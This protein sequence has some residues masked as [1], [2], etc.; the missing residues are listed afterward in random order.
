MACLRADVPRSC[1][2]HP[3]TSTYGYAN[4]AIIAPKMAS[5]VTPLL[6]LTPKGLNAAISNGVSLSWTGLVGAT[7]YNIQRATN[8]G[9]PYMWIG[10]TTATHF[11]DST[12]TNAI[13]YSF[14]HP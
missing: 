2:L 9:G 11:I 7:N 4:L 13:S 12:A 10:S 6:A 8:G 3:Q 5:L 1:Y 14:G